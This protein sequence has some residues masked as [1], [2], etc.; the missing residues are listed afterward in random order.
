MNFVLYVVYRWHPKSKM[1]NGGPQI[2]ASMLFKTETKSIR[3][4]FQM[5]VEAQ[6]VPA[7]QRCSRQLEATA[8]FQK[9]KI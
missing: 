7:Q 3:A 4:F 9:Y 5:H 2:T 8:Q 1:I 6:G